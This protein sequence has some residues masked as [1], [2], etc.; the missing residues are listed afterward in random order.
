MYGY[1]K[2]RQN[3]RKNIFEAVPVSK[4]PGTMLS[5]LTQKI[6]SSIIPV[7]RGPIL[8]IFVAVSMMNIIIYSP[9]MSCV[10]R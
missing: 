1:K 6:R 4:I 2:E 8:V 9:F 10:F 3:W 7:C 5:A